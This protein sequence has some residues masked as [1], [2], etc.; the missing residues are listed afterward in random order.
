[1]SKKDFTHQ[2]ILGYLM[3]VIISYF[4]K[5]CK[6]YFIYFFQ[7]MIFSPVVIFKYNFIH[8]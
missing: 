3:S 5:F 4:F 6:L 8:I 2:I 1:M 7:V